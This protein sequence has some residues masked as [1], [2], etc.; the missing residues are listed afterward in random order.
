MN[1]ELISSDILIILSLTTLVLFLTLHLKLPA[2]VGFLVTGI[3]IGPNG[4]GL[5]SKIE[6]ASEIA[7][8]GIVLLLFTIGIEF[9]LRNLLYYKKYLFFGGG[10]QVGLTV[11]AGLLIGKL[12]SRPLGEAIFLGFLLSLS[13]TAI[14]LRIMEERDELSSSQSKFILSALIFQDLIVVPM[15]FLVPALGSG[16]FE[17]DADIPF[18]LI[19]IF[20]VVPIAVF[21]AYKVIPSLMHYVA[22]T[23]SR[24]LFIITI[25]TICMTVTYISWKIGLSFSLGAF[26]SGLII[27][28]SEY[29]HEAM[30]TV[31][32]IKDFFLSLYFVFIG[33]L[34][35]IHFLMEY[36][37]LILAAA[38]GVQVMKALIVFFVCQL[39]RL[40]LRVSIISAIALSQIGEFSFVLM[41]EGVEN[42]ISTA[43]HYQLFL[44]VSLITMA[45][46]PFLFNLSSKLDDW[47]DFIPL[48]ER[49]KSGLRIKERQEEK[50][51]DHMIIV[52]M[53]L[54]GRNLAMAAKKLGIPYIA[55]DLSS[56]GKEEGEPIIFADATHES[57][58]RH[59]R[60]ASAK[61]IAIMIS[62]PLATRRIVKWARRLNNDIA[63]MVRTRHYREA[64]YIAKTGADEVVVDDLESSYE[65]LNRLMKL[66]SIP[67]DTEKELIEKMRRD[68]YAPLNKGTV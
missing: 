29:K 49:L 42:G 4:L 55:L 61:C 46:T 31:I 47:I 1:I 15:V 8:I 37:L 65:M 33:M 57:V 26:L 50:Y 14:V 19:K 59:A 56:E 35:D 34:L 5:I 30:G 38:I 58:L 22:K 44:A 2:L 66:F 9:S 12:L 23:K 48:P 62:D 18:L 7:N 43:F 28:E 41:K 25:L 13:S 20:L 68:G 3:L 45:L 51:R 52:G 60:I 11:L 53:S 27:S 67:A 39:L 36:P 21:L 64:E 40:S 10:L 63:I 17:F 6:E 16:N 32:P 24:E 54:P